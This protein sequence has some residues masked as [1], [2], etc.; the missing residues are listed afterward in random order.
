M[1]NMHEVID[2]SPTQVSTEL[3]HVHGRCEIRLE[4]HLDERW[5]DWFEGLSLT[6]ESDGT[7]T[8]DGRLS[9]QAALHGVFNKLRDL[10]VLLI[11]VHYVS[12]YSKKA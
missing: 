10:G 9:D 4:G 1:S 8:L 6:H 11:S 3:Y 5:A 12:S 7:T 2:M